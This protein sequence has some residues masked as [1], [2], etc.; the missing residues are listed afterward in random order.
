M[1]ERE[2]ATERTQ[3]PSITP[4][5]L[6]RRWSRGEKVEIIDVR[7][8]ISFAEVHVPNATSVPFETLDPHEVMARRQSSKNDPLY[9]ICQIGVRSLDAAERFM[10]A[11]FTNVV[12]VE[13]GTRDWQDEGLPVVHERQRGLPLRRQVQLTAGSLVVAGS[14]VGL[15]LNPV[16]IGIATAVGAGLIYTAATDNCAMAIVLAKMPWNRPERI[17]GALSQPLPHGQHSRA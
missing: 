9:I 15:L 14:V 1:T 16:F 13:G 17:I 8:A 7:F 10:E 3:I 11:G 12:N 5:D 6:Y 4:K 2:P